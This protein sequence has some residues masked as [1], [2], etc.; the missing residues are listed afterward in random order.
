MPSEGRD[1]EM[2][3]VSAPSPRR[4]T[5]EQGYLSRDVEMSHEHAERATTTPRAKNGQQRGQLTSPSSQRNGQ[6]PP[7]N[8]NNGP[9]GKVKEEDNGISPTKLAAKQIKFHKEVSRLQDALDD[10]ST[11]VARNVLHSNWRRFIFEG[12]DEIHIGFIL[13]AILKNATPDVLERVARDGGLFKGPMLQAAVENKV[14]INSIISDTDHVPL[15][16]K[17]MSPDELFSALPPNFIDKAI[18]DRISTVEAPQLVA[19]LAA[20]GRLGFRNDD[21]IGAD[22]IVT[23]NLAIAEPTTLSQREEN[24]A[25][26]VI[27]LLRGSEFP[28]RPAPSA[29]PRPLPARQDPLI[30]HT[31]KKSFT[32][33]SGFNYHQLKNI[34]EKTP[35]STGWKWACENCLQ[36]FTTKQGREYHNLKHVCESSGIHPASEFTESPQSGPN[37]AP[38]TIQRPPMRNPSLPRSSSQVPRKSL[39]NQAGSEHHF[40]S[41]VP[42]NAY[43]DLVSGTP[44]AR[45]PMYTPISTNTSPSL[46]TGSRKQRSDRDIRQPPEDLPPEKLAAMNREIEEAND[47]YEALKQEILQMSPGEH[48]ARLQS[49]KNLNASKKSNI[50]KRYGVT[51]RMREKDKL[52]AGTMKNTSSKLRA[53]FSANEETL[54]PKSYAAPPSSISSVQMNTIVAAPQGFSPINAGR[55]PEL[56]TSNSYHNNLPTLPAPPALPYMYNPYGS[57]SGP[58]YIPP[59][60]PPPLSMRPPMGSS[61]KNDKSVKEKPINYA[62]QNQQTPASYAVNNNLKRRR[63][64]SQTRDEGSAR[65]SPAYVPYRTPYEAIPNSS[66]PTNRSAQLQMKEVSSQPAAGKFPNKTLAEPQGKWSAMRQSQSASNTPAASPAGSTVDEKASLTPGDVTMPDV[67]ATDVE[68]ASSAVNTPINDG[69]VPKTETPSSGSK[70]KPVIELSDTESDDNEDI[71]NDNY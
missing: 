13:R 49:A 28:M 20:A 61:D 70:K 16:A 51:L 64:D 2:V 53:S 30:C 31:C 41:S 60:Q 29:A 42:I 44:V 43:Y 59:Q 11:D 57:P 19:W 26:G 4:D 36:G 63:S 12:Y 23:P 69:V 58:S 39:D 40:P 47:K 71:P 62:P 56:R 22:E 33:L 7:S 3:D 25:L 35:P 67:P 1:S 50:R 27:N 9:N 18:A 21:L 17:H 5:S 37:I 10:V 14:V 46:G 68:S 54:T 52:A 8:S 32:S 38:N 66:T 48:E 65:P 6:A 45:P 34:C 24:D 15:L 55:G